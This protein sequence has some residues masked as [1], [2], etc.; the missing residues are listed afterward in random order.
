MIPLVP[1]SKFQ[2]QFGAGVQESESVEEVE[3]LEVQLVETRSRGLDAERPSTPFI[4]NN[5]AF[6]G[7]DLAD[8]RMLS[9][10]PKVDHP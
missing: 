3:G 10:V 9:V 2:G 5:I 4:V 8:T 6:T 1:F 7:N